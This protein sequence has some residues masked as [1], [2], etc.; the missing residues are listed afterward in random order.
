MF[1]LDSQLIPSQRVY[2]GLTYSDTIGVLSLNSFRPKAPNSGFTYNDTP[3]VVALNRALQLEHTAVAIYAAKQ[4][5]STSLDGRAGASAIDRTESHN[6]ALRQLVQL[7]FAQKGLPDSGPA[8]LTALTGT[9]AARVSR[10]M[11][12]LVQDPMLGVSAQ[13]VEYALARRYRQLLNI[14]PES[15]REIIKILLNQ[16]VVFAAADV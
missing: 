2:N 9:V 8:G 5:R 13:R 12:P 3:Y 1:A 7:I 4:R 11:P 6:K 15:D 10:F 16:T 14:A